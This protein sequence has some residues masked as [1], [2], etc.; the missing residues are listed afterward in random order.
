MA[1]GLEHLQI[2]T[3]NCSS[4]TISGCY[5]TGVAMPTVLQVVNLAWTLR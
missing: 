4:P 2:R 3:E 5:L 1:T